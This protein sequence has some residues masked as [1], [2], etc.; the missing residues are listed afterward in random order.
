MCAVNK[1][2]IDRSG[3]IHTP[4]I[5]SLAAE[6]VILDQYYA[7]DVCSPSR[8]S[9][10]TGRYAMHHTI[11]DW[12]PP[13]SAYGLPLNLTTMADMFKAAN[14]ETRAVGKWHLGSWQSR[15]HYAQ[16]RER[17]PSAASHCVRNLTTLDGG[18]S[19]VCT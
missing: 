7:Q 14:Y 4:V 12:I 19:H 6:G 1:P 8:A 17:S 9:F 16:D 11:V 13:P 15:M 5:D 2:C 18:P 3:D 10:M